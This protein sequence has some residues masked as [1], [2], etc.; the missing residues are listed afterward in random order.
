MA[1]PF[2]KYPFLVVY[3][4]YIL[5]AIARY[6]GSLMRNTVPFLKVFLIPFLLLLIIIVCLVLS[7]KIYLVVFK[8]IINAL[9]LLSFFF[10]FKLIIDSREKLKFFIDNFMHQIIVFALLTS[11]FTFFVLFDIFSFHD[12][13]PHNLTSV[14]QQK[15]SIDIDNNFALLPGFFGMLSIFYTIGK[16]KSRRVIVLF[17][18][19]LS[20]FSLSVLLSA[21]KRGLISMLLIISALILVK[22]LF[23]LKKKRGDLFNE[24]NSVANYYFL[25]ISFL[26]LFSYAFLFLTNYSFKNSTFKLLGTGNVPAAFNRVTKNLFEYIQL[27]KPNASYSDLYK[28]IWRPVIDPR[29]PESGWGVR[30]HKTVEKLSGT[31]VE[32]VPE[33]SKGYLLDN[34]CNADTREGNAYAYTL[35]WNDGI[36]KRNVTG[37]TVYCYVSEEYDG[38]YAM[39]AFE[40]IGTQYKRVSYDLSKKGTWQKLSLEFNYEKQEAPVY[41]YIAK[42]GVTD[43][44]TLKGYVIF[45]FPHIN[46]ASVSLVSEIHQLNYASFVTIPLRLNLKAKFFSSGDPKI[47]D[48][49]AGYDKDPIRRWTHKFISE[50]PAYSR[51]KSRIVIDTIRDNFISMRIVHWNFAWQIFTCEYNLKQKF[52]GEGFRFLNWYG[53]YFMNDKTAS[54][55]PHNPFLSVLLYSG[56]LGLLFYLFALFRVF[57]VYIKFIKEYPVI[58]LC[59]LLTFFFTFFSGSSPFDPPVMGFFFMVPFLIQHIHMQ[60]NGLM[61]TSG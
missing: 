40:G 12:L 22:I 39:M 26:A 30:N 10:F 8:D 53:D 14:Y 55:W 48:T 11:C 59:F 31:N 6:R 54:D 23:S 35:I 49:V 56:I 24:L 9:I 3:V 33:G 2:F 57:Y 51:L 13:V 7:N 27:F 16:V 5:F 41:L 29:E 37:A 36:N 43:F 61:N 28:K 21:S 1:V 19:L 20:F 15:D 32:I 25:S 18:L 4:A 45:A 34:T 38:D 46:V 50:D 60:K 17:I 52:T 44:S 47:T 58:F 42:F